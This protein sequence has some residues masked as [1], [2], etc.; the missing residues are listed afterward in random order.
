MLLGVLPWIEANASVLTSGPHLGPAPSRG[1]A[2]TGALPRIVGIPSREYVAP[3]PLD[4]DIAAI[5]SH[6]FGHDSTVLS[7]CL[8]PRRTSKRIRKLVINWN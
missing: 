5:K 3:K 8:I 2:A 7:I 1:G 4:S 6:S